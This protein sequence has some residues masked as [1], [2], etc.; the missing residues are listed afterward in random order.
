MDA[1]ERLRDSWS[2]L[3]DGAAARAALPVGIGEAI[4]AAKQIAALSLWFNP[5]DLW[6]SMRQRATPDQIWLEHLRRTCT[7]D[8]ADVTQWMML[9]HERLPR[10]ARLSADGRLLREA[11]RVARRRSDEVPTLVS[12]M[13]RGTYEPRSAPTRTL[14]T[15]TEVLRWL[16][17]I[18]AQLTLPDQSEMAGLVELRARDS[19]LAQ[20]AHNIVGREDERRMLTQFVHQAWR[21]SARTLPLF[22]LHGIGGI[23]KSTLAAEFA[24]NALPRT[25]SDALLIWIDYDK[26]RIRPDD[27]RTFM[28]EVA[29]QLAWSLP[30]R[31]EQLRAARVA[32]RAMDR[33]ASDR[34]TARAAIDTLSAALGPSVEGRRDRPVV[35]VLD[36]FEQVERAP[37]QTADIL[38]V[39]DNMRG[40]LFN[41]FAVIACGRAVFS[42]GFGDVP[43]AD[44]TKPLRGLSRK[45]SH[46]LLTGRGG[47]SDLAADKL[48]DA[49]AD[50][51]DDQFRDRVGVP[52]LLM[53][54]ARLIREK[55]F[56]LDGRDLAEIRE[57]ADGTMATAYIYGRVLR[58]V[59]HD[60]R[61]LAH[62]GLVLA[63]VS[64]ESIEN[65]LWPAVHGQ[66]AAIG[67]DRA[68]ALFKRLQSETWLVEPVPGSRPHRVRHRPD[69]RRAML[70]KMRH[71]PAPVVRVT[72]HRLH[73]MARD[74]HRSMRRP[75]RGT[76]ERQ[77]HD[78]GLA[79][80]AL[81]LSAL[82]GKPA[83]VGIGLIRAVREELAYAIDDF[84]LD[85]QPVVRALLGESIEPHQ[86][87]KLESSLRTAVVADLSRSF[88]LRGDHA[89]G[90]DFAA[91][92]D[93]RD[94]ERTPAIAR[95]AVS[96]FLA[97]GRWRSAAPLAAP[98]VLG[99]RPRAL[100]FARAMPRLRPYMAAFVIDGM[101]GVEHALGDAHRR[102]K[103]GSIERRLNLYRSLFAFVDAPDTR[104]RDL[105]LKRAGNFIGEQPARRL[106]EEML[107]VARAYGALLLT[108][109]PGRRSMSPLQAAARRGALTAGV[110]TLRQMEAL[111]RPSRTSAQWISAC[112]AM[113]RQLERDERLASELPL[114]IT[115]EQFHLPLGEALA[116]DLPDQ[117]SVYRI[118]TR[119]WD[120][121]DVRPAD[122][123]PSTFAD[124]CA[125]PRAR[126]ER[127]RTLVT[128]LDR[129]D[130]LG[131]FLEELGRDAPRTATGDLQRVAEV[132]LAW[133]DAFVSRGR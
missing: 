13:L 7:V 92:L 133:R 104:S 111:D 85:Y 6:R 83:R 71:D 54:I 72:L 68:Q 74:W 109:D 5:V 34:T 43:V 27:I 51:T 53:L 117:S 81:Q 24:L 32:I 122:L 114:A 59:P 61:E 88:A 55:Q 119:A 23:G 56:E 99:H 46:H 22:R 28:L 101:A 94:L 131:P 19:E 103:N 50:L 69:L 87:A 3:M 8:A 10:L 80:H 67:P 15:A 64:A 130:R 124:A 132:A 48:L 78:F 40:M 126:R 25:K 11:D 17:A 57:S 82:T 86:L 2:A 63:E 65:V 91:M 37:N 121:I 73:A 106:G 21:S 35:L 112:R 128:F 108:G 33:I 42:Q 47:L 44:Q 30:E 97:S 16:S 49:F 58:Q 52:M 100:E 39:L 127:M 95:G 9:D 118:A 60:L 120:L 113:D 90:L 66:E 89:G 41:Q 129:T 116:D 38:G 123:R 105:F 29:R 110:S 14:A 98:L 125:D 18:D 76:P 93:P 45:A 20:L 62:P 115:F 4:E 70:V 77:H 96:A 31:A 26:L 12:A 36:T 107:P 75:T 102:P 1:F 79:Y 84:P